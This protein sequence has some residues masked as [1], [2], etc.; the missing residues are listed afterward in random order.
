MPYLYI[1]QGTILGCKIY[2]YKKLVMFLAHLNFQ[3][4]SP[5]IFPYIFLLVSYYIF[6]S[7]VGFITSVFIINIKSAGLRMF[8]V[9]LY[10]V[11]NTVKTNYSERDILGNS[12]FG[13]IQLYYGNKRT[14]KENKFQ[15]S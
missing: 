5:Y 12:L 2:L 1:F 9:P 10:M 14:E 7:R 15:Y 4:Y 3:Y 11:K 6:L 8:G 13:R